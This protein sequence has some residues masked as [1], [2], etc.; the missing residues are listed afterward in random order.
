MARPSK[1]LFLRSDNCWILISSR[2]MWHLVFRQKHRWI[3]WPTT[4]VQSN[5]QLH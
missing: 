3:R 1:Y 5:Q 2:W 4:K